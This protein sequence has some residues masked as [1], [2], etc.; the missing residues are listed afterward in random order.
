VFSET[1]FD[2]GK[3]TFVQQEPVGDTLGIKVAANNIPS[4]VDAIRKS[5][6]GMGEVN[7]HETVVGRR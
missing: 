4:S 5:L 3:G 6:G 7:S 1:A 2:S